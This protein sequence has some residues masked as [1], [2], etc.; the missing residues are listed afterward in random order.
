[1]DLLE[2]LRIGPCC[3]ALRELAD[4][5]S[6]ILATGFPKVPTLGIQGLTVPSVGKDSSAEPGRA[7][8]DVIEGHSAPPATKTNCAQLQGNLLSESVKVS[9]EFRHQLLQSPSGVLQV[10][11]AGSGP[12]CLLKLL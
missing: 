8:P 2:D 11:V 9:A 12:G 7:A 6:A 5:D 10:D 4:V 3:N 1:M